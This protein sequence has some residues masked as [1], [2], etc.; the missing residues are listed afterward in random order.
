[1]TLLAGRE[2][3]YHE[4]VFVLE[5]NDDKH[6]DDVTYDLDGGCFAD[7]SSC[8]SANSLASLTVAQQG[9]RC[10]TKGQN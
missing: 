2:K 7:C 3:V 9:S 5:D 1:M 10:F 4:V 8:L 6:I